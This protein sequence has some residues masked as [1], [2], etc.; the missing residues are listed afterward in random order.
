[1]RN[2]LYTVGS[3]LLLGGVTA[4]SGGGGAASGLPTVTTA[5]GLPSGISSSHSAKTS[6]V[7]AYTYTAPWNGFS[8]QQTAILNPQGNCEHIPVTQASGYTWPG[9]LSSLATGTIVTVSGTPSYLNSWSVGVGCPTG[10]IVATNIIVGTP[11]PIPSPTP[12]ATPTP[13]P[14]PVPTPR[15]TPT[16]TPTPA[17]AP[18]PTASV[19]TYVAPWNGFASKTTAILNPQGQCEHI[20]VTQASGFTWPTFLNSLAAGTV[21]T[22]TGTPS[23]ADSWSRSVGCPTGGIVATGIAIGNVKPT[24]APSSTPSTAPAPTP[25][26]VSGPGLPFGTLPSAYEVPSGWRPYAANSTWNQQLGSAPQLD[27]NDAQKINW[28]FSNNFNGGQNT[29]QMMETVPFNPRASVE[30]TPLYFAKTSDPLVKIQCTS[31]FG[32]GGNNACPLPAQLNVPQLAAAATDSDHHIIIVQANG[33]EADIWEWQTSPPYHSGQTIQVGW[34]GP[35]NVTTGTGWDHGLDNGAATVSGNDLLGGYVFASEIAAGQINHA[36]AVDLPCNPVTQVYPALIGGG[37]F[38]NCSGA[39]N[40]GTAPIAIGSR[41]WLD[42]PDATINSYPISNGEKTLLRALHDYGAFH[43]DTNNYAFE[44]MSL[45]SPEP[46]AIYGN[47]FA[48]PIYAANLY[49]GLGGYAIGI[50]GQGTGSDDFD[51]YV[52]PHLHVLAPC[53]NNGYPGGQCAH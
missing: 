7:A 44:L 32:P 49:T 52:K 23:Y 30:A 2:N 39:T 6:S 15:P 14:T 50:T 33:V 37:S 51:K 45:E 46:G 8:N 19:Y 11:T 9:F 53:V 1:M 42:T 34:G 16:P 31:G 10:G 25:T 24:P 38:T 12:T 5:S 17:P 29:D 27:P 4:C 18:I 41:F 3:L 47:N 20:P 48:T 13:S 22:V 26:P 28:L 21:V 35:A 43:I 40:T 36:L